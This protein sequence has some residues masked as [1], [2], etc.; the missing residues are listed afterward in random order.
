MKFTYFK[1]I[2][3]YSGRTLLV[4]GCRL[5]TQR[6]EMMFNARIFTRVVKPDFTVHSRGASLHRGAFSASRDTNVIPRVYFVERRIHFFLIIRHFAS[7]L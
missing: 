7:C 3:K 2:F 1:T 4:S 6:V 5:R